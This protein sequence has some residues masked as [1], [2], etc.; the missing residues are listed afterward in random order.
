MTHADERDDRNE[1][2]SD[3]L[4]ESML[5]ESTVTSAGAD[6]A[7]PPE[8]RAPNAPRSITDDAAETEDRES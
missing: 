3:G 8:P 4:T 7:P 2:D 5:R 6:P 1:L